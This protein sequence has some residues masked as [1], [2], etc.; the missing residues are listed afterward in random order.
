MLEK[1][2]API[3]GKVVNAAVAFCKERPMF[4]VGFGL[5]MLGIGDVL[6]VKAAVESA[7]DIREI[8]TTSE[9]IRGTGEITQAEKAKALTSVYIHT[10]GKIAKRFAPTVALKAVGT[11]C[12]VGAA[13]QLNVNAITAGAT[14]S[15]LEAH[16]E[17]LYKRIEDKYG[18]EEAHNLRYNIVEKDIE[19][20]QLRKDGTVKKVTKKVMVPDPNGYI[21][22]LERYYDQSNPT[23]DRGLNGYITNVQRIRNTTIWAQ[24]KLD[25]GYIVKWNDFF[26]SDGFEPVIA[27]YNHGWEPGDTIDLGV[28][29]YPQTNEEAMQWG[30]CVLLRPNCHKLFDVTDDEKCFKTNIYGKIA[31]DSL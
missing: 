23:F 9:R 25:A 24:K 21:P 16:L 22:L 1:F 2:V 10:G 27:G 8:E 6:M 3:G 14:V 30:D 19:E 7:D 4:V 28:N 18:A 17:N 5:S 13:N 29:L 31:R 11:V 20:E 12:V 26:P 15:M